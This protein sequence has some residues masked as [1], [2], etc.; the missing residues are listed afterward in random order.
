MDMY[1]E[2]DLYRLT[3]KSDENAINPREEDNLGNLI[4]FG[5]FRSVGDKHL[6][7]S[8]EEFLR[9]LLDS[10]PSEELLGTL[11]YLPRGDKEDLY[12]EVFETY[13]NDMA[14]EISL[15]DVLLELGE[16]L[17]KDQELLVGELALEANPDY[18][19]EIESIDFSLSV[20]EELVSK[21]ETIT[22]LPVFFYDHGGLSVN[23]GGF[24]CP[25]DS[26]QAGWIFATQQ[27]AT[28][29]GIEKDSIQSFLEK[30]VKELNMF[31][32]G[33]VYK[34]ILEEK[35]TCSY[36]GNVSY[37]FIDSCGGFYASSAKELAEE[38]KGYLPEDL[39][40]LD[41]VL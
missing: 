33:D 2:N 16:N 32:Q 17:N 14:R 24:S 23:T 35:N 10:V 19:R 29:Y 41:G 31:L 8:P 9:E 38:I 11:D 12:L 4:L 34:Y 15:P 6:Y 13:F 22:I 36:C 37:E 18:A 3:I 5:S 27:E 25:W 20:L 21:L 7:T 40:L 30:E 1:K 28:E 39:D 26:G